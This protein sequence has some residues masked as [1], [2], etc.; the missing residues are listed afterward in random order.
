MRLGHN[1]GTCK[2]LL[3]SE[4]LSNQCLLSSFMSTTS[5]LP[6]P[7]PLSA[8]SISDVTTSPMVSKLSPDHREM[9][10]Q[11][12]DVGSWLWDTERWYGFDE[13]QS[14]LNDSS[15]TSNGLVRIIQT[16][17]PMTEQ[18]LHD[19]SKYVQSLQVAVIMDDK[20]H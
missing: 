6:I 13:M 4:E 18:E 14:V 9:L 15:K 20:A 2:N 12:G 7:A 17:G 8:A 5:H 3:C 19:I 10:T 11:V 16:K 1:G